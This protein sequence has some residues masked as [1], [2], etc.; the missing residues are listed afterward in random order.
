VTCEHKQVLAHAGRQA[1][2][3]HPPHHDLRKHNVTCEDK[4]VLARA[5]RQAVALH[6]PHHDLRKHN[7]TCE[8]KQVQAGRQSHCTHLIT[9]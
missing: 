3:L 6:P 2:A 9:T 1:V 8:N 5:G 7:V 4:Q